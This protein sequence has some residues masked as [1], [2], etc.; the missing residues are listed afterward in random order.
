M[1][2]LYFEGVSHYRENLVCDVSKAADILSARGFFFS[3]NFT[4][5]D[6][7]LSNLHGGLYG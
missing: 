6:F 3:G 2:L 7:Q 1:L 5:R 4:L